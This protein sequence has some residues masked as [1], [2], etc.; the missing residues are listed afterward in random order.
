MPLHVKLLAAADWLDVERTKTPLGG[1]DRG[2]ANPAQ[3]TTMQIGRDE[4]YLANARGTVYDQ[5]S[6][7]VGRAD[8]TGVYAPPL[9]PGGPERAMGPFSTTAS[10]LYDLPGLTLVLDEKAI[11]LRIDEPKW[12]LHAHDAFLLEVVP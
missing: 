2:T 6:R 8:G 3:W 4:V 12:Q 1:P 10:G 7:P 11:T 9:S 5:Y